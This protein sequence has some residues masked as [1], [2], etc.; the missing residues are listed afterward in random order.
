MQS[1]HT[2]SAS[3]T[4]TSTDLNADSISEQISAQIMETEARLA[5]L[6]EAFIRAAEVHI[7][8][9]HERSRR[10]KDFQMKGTDLQIMWKTRRLLA[11]RLERQQKAQRV[12]AAGNTE[13]AAALTNRD[14][15]GLGLPEPMPQGETE[16]S[17]EA[18]TS[19]EARSAGAGAAAKPRPS[20]TSHPRK[21]VKHGKRAA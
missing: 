15:A 5:T 18:K 14:S 9:L 13:R 20:Y 3:N 16:P 1:N 19:T 11:E 4:N 8:K 17:P 7:D 10:E 2:P 12:L 21:R 6:E